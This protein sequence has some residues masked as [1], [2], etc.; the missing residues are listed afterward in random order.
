MGQVTFDTIPTS[1]ETENS[2][3]DKSSSNSDT[4]KDDSPGK[5]EMS[6]GSHESQ[7][8]ESSTSDTSCFPKLPRQQAPEII[9]LS[10]TTSRPAVT[11]RTDE[12]LDVFYG[13]C[14]PVPMVEMQCANNDRVSKMPDKLNPYQLLY[15]CLI[16]N[17]HGPPR[18]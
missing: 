17:M 18:E 1:A 13:V 6:S 4:G 8:K 10:V 9:D 15:R 7:G 3:N 5:K 14:W 2:R 12:L 16:Y 11:N